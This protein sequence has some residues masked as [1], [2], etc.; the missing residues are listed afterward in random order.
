MNLGNLGNYFVFQIWFYNFVGKATGFVVS[1]MMG[2]LV[3][4]N[5][6]QRQQQKKVVGSGVV[7]ELKTIDVVFADMKH[8]TYRG[9]SLVSSKKLEGTSKVQIVEFFVVYESNIQF[10]TFQFE[11]RSIHKGL[12][13]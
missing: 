10:K 4:Q 3:W 1:V 8:A 13:I 7:F 9:I 5:Q 12:P 2:R 11:I 6:K